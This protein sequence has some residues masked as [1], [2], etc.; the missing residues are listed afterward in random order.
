MIQFAY[1]FL[2]RLLAPFVFGLFLWRGLRDRGYWRGLHE[3]LGFGQRLSEPSI[4]VHAVSV[5]EVQAATSLLRALAARYPQIPLVLTTG[6]PTGRARALANLGDDVELRYLPYDSPG[7]VAR[8]F[9]RVRPKIAIIIEKELWPNL[10]RECGLRKVPLVLASAAVSPRS[11]GR[12]RRLVV[13]FRETLSHGL[14]IAAQSTED[15]ARFIEIGAPASRTHVV[16]NIKFD[17]VLPLDAVQQ[18]KSWRTHY[19]AESCFTLVAGSTYEAEERALLQTSAALQ[20]A[21]IVHL[22]VIAPRHPPRFEAVA[23]RLQSAGVDFVRHSL[24]KI[25]RVQARP[26]LLLLDTL[27]ELAGFYAIA[28]VAFVGG[29]LLDGVGGHNPLEPAALAV[30]VL[31]G[32]H[33]FNTREIVET[34]MAEQGLQQ[35]A[36]SKEL[37]QA[38]IE[39]ARNETL[40]QARGRAALS[41]VERNRGTIARLMQLLEPLIEPA[42]RR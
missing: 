39:L 22:L 18:G 40:R 36:S 2:V 16:G 31:M 6:T 27:G 26:Q 4:W 20:A 29:S 11:V 24:S 32:P 38:V 30:P 9:D 19:H 21:G 14:V 8:F 12:Y 17:A 41:V 5:G 33:V 28:D 23:Q 3:R 15:A 1:Q 10:Y 7:A 34:L 25:E 37:S 35:V 42:P 13:L